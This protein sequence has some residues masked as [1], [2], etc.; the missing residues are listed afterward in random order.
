[1]AN[2]Q[3]DPAE[4]L[5]QYPGLK[6]QDADDR[7]LVF[8]EFI[9]NVPREKCFPL[10]AGT[11]ASPYAKLSPHPRWGAKW[12]VIDAEIKGGDD[13]G[14]NLLVTYAYDVR[15][16]LES[17]SAFES[18]LA[19]TNKVTTFPGY[20]TSQDI[21]WKLRILDPD[22]NSYTKPSL[23]AAHPT[24]SNCLF[25]TESQTRDGPWLMVNRHYR[26]VPATTEQKMHGDGLGICQSSTLSLAVT[27]A[28]DVKKGTVYLYL[29]PIDQRG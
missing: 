15:N 23:A 16:A 24:T 19:K 17:Q 25:I 11:F 26:Q 22:A 28:G 13:K 21:L 9:P 29:L 6:T 12:K 27:N 10:S 14:N 2:L 4:Y 20:G 5:A 7:T 18:Y 3:R 1:M 8:Q